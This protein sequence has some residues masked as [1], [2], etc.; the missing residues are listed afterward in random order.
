MD[1]ELRTLFR[2]NLPKL[3]WQSIESGGTGRGIL[4]SNF[5]FQGKEGW[6]EFKATGHWTIGLRPEQAAW[7]ARRTRAGGR[8]FVAVRRARE[9]L[10][11][12]RGSLI[13]ADSLKGLDGA[14]VWRGGPKNWPWPQ[15]QAALL[16]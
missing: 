13:P 10:W 16:A 12:I 4:D 7:I 14:L 6:V 8:T 5:C 1:G 2:V 3:N 9:E 11:L 15:V